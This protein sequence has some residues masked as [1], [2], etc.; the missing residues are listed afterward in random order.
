MTNKKRTVAE[1]AKLVE[2]ESV[3]DDKL[4][5]TG[6]A[7]LETASTGDI[8][9][10]VKA[11]D[12]RLLADFQGSAVIVPEEIEELELPII[13]V[14][15][16]YLAAAKIHTLL[17]EEEFVAKGVHARAYVHES[18]PV[19]EQ[20]AVAPL[21]CIGARVQLGERVVI[22]SG[23]VIEDDVEIG[24]DTL[25]KSNVTIEKGCKIGN[26]VIIHA[27]AVIG[28]D[29]YGYATDKMGTHFKRPQVGIVQIDD[30]VEIGAN[31]CVDRAAY[32]VTHIK[33]GAKIDNLVMIAHNV[34]IGENSLLVSQVG[35][36]G[37]TTLGRN[38][39]LGGQVGL[40]DHLTFGDGV[41]VA[42]GSGVHN[43]QEDGAMIGGYPAL[44]M[45]QWVRSVSQFTKLPQMG[46]D[47]R[48]VKKAVAALEDEEK[49]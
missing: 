30:D 12:K 41:M 8:S 27:G 19:P 29:G 26:R 42:G 15:D 28:S 21:A 33:A 45:R 34:V 10:L 31:S 22:D 24:D 14:Q 40:A 17:L 1:L 16:P 6:F 32:G 20:I 2:G 47:L 48:R 13:R 36:A 5:I 44:P 46:R 3:G 4:V 38:V 23:V 49:E 37:S 43:N 9:F 39:V 35:I 18:T 11:K 25:L 7:P